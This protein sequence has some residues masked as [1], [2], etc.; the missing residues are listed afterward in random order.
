MRKGVNIFLGDALDHYVSWP[1]P[2][3]IISDGAYGISGFDGDPSSPEGLR[4]WYAPHVQ[5]WTKRASPQ[6]TL[7]FW[8][9]EVG[10]ANTHPLLVEH[11]W[12]YEHLI[13]WDKGLGHIAGNVNSK[14]IRSLP[15]V[16]E[17]CA[18]YTRPIVFT[19]G[20]NTLD[21]RLWLRSEWER[22]GFPWNDANIACGV[23]AAA[24]RKYLGLDEQ[25]Y[26]PPPE[27]FQKLADYANEHGSPAGRPYFSW[28]TEYDPE[29][30]RYKKIRAKWNHIHGL[31]NVWSHP[32]VRGKERFRFEGS[33]LHPNQKP[34]KLLQ[35]CVSLSTDPGDVVWEPF[36]GLCSGVCAA[37][38]LDRRGYAAEIQEEFYKVAVES[39]GDGILELL[40]G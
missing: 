36:G 31:T 39:M 9:T 19:N 7:W 12:V 4:E 29:N 8:N 11:G 33:I 35:R 27:I 26:P 5:A 16:T 28:G 37:A 38:S 6:T 34:V 3:C 2:T 15:V 22:T 17:V 32:A 40:N 13:T 14:T 21:L 23:Q 18:R 1:E 24:T 30:L 10:W 25:W 20:E